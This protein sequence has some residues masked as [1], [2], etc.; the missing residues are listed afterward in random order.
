MRPLGCTL[1][2]KPQ[3]FVRQQ[4]RNPKAQSAQREGQPVLHQARDA[5]PLLGTATST[6][7]ASRSQKYPELLSQ[8]DSALSSVKKRISH[9]LLDSKKKL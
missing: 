4:K 6:A 9:S 8:V 2:I 1:A 3:T 5:T 7:S